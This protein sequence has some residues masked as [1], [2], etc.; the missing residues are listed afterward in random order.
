M[1]SC[2]WY[3]ENPEKTFGE[4]EALMEND[5]DSALYL[6]E[7]IPLPRSLSEKHYSEYSLLTVMVKDKLDEDLVKDTLVVKARDYYVKTDNMKKAAQASFYLGRALQAAKDNEGA[8]N[9]YKDAETYAA[10]INDNN[11][12]GLIQ[13]DLGLLMFHQITKDGAIVRLKSAAEYFKADKKYRNEIIAY[14]HIGRAFHVNN[15][16]D[17]ALYYYDK[18]FSLATIHKDTIE[19][20]LV[21]MNRGLVYESMGRKDTARILHKDALK[22]LKSSEHLVKA[23]ANIARTFDGRAEKDSIL[24]YTDKAQTMFDEKER[25]ELK[26]SIS[27]LLSIVEESIDNHPKA[28]EYHKEYTDNLIDYYSKANEQEVLKAN[29][30]Y[31]FERMRNE[32]NQLTIEKQSGYMAIL[33]LAVVLLIISLLFYINNSQKKKKVLEVQQ[34]VIHLRKLANTYDEEKVSIRNVMLRHFDILKKTILLEGYMTKDERKQ[35]EKLLK[36]FNEIVYEKETLDWEILF[37]TMNHVSNGFPDKLKE[38]YPDLDLTDIKI[39]CLTEADLS[40]TEIALILNLSVNT[41]QTKKSNIRR[42]IG[43]GGYKDIIEHIK[44]NL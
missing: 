39:C 25:P 12:K 37:K 31:D 30:K 17:S 44:K 10:N 43:I 20:A 7:M 11:L 29:T 35:G 40:N 16:V 33:A 38:T 34:Q 5:P 21:K 18:S 9:A 13:F 28:L 14:N 2:N 24:F 41:I 3:R 19:Q 42:K 22:S 15:N 6:L 32:N 8:T 4:V 1:F 23:Y 26:A 27:K 36:K